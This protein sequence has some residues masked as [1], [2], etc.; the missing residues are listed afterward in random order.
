MNYKILKIILLFVLLFVLY[1]NLPKNITLD[2]FEDTKICQSSK[3]DD[4]LYMCL[5]N[6][7]CC[8]NNLTDNCF[9]NNKNITNCYQ[10]K[11][12]CEKRMCNN[13]K[14]DICD[15]LHNNCCNEIS[16]NNSVINDSSKKQTDLY[17]KKQKMNSDDYMCRMNGK[18]N[19][20][21]CMHICDVTPK[22]NG[23]AVSVGGRICSL[24]E[25]SPQLFSSENSEYYVKK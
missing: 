14:C 10:L 22:C 17:S 25:K 18:Y 8:E 15:N 16:K 1:L 5:N 11:S 7:I 2:K 24:Y 4:S 21:K 20:S 13:K 19:K 12:D 23:F 6:D 9:C 3:R